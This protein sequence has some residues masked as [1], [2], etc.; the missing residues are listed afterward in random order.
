MTPLATALGGIKRSWL[1]AVLVLGSLPNPTAAT[2]AYEP[3]QYGP[4]P[5]DGSPGV[6]YRTYEPHQRRATSLL[7]PPAPS[8]AATLPAAWSNGGSANVVISQDNRDARLIAYDS[9]ASNLVVGDSNGLRDVFVIRRANGAANFAGRTTLASV[10]GRATRANG[11]SSKPSL[12]GDTWHAPHCVAFESGATNLSSGDRSRD[13]DVY[14]R[15]LGARR[16]LL[17]SPG[18]RDAHEPVIDGSCRTVIFTARGAVWIARVKAPRPRFIARGGDAD[19]QTNGRGVAYARGGQVWY[20]ALEFRGK[21]LVRGRERLVSVTA[22]SRPG[23]GPSASPALDDRGYYVAFESTASNLCVGQC[24]LHDTNGAT[25]DVFRRT[26]SHSAPSHDLMQI[27][28]MSQGGVLQPGPSNNPVISANGENVVFDSAAFMT[29]SGGS[30]DSYNSN[31]TARSVYTWTYPHARGYGN[32]ANVAPR[33]HCYR[34]CRS[35]E[36]R[37]AMSSRGNYVAYV[38]QMSEFCVTDRIFHF[39]G[40]R[41]DCPQ[42][43][44]VFITY[45]G[46]SH[47]GRKLG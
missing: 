36:E 40:E 22:R 41:P 26:M 10:A 19:L 39:D 28:S 38:S 24:Q 11:P 42:F 43:Q 13:A 25:S 12:D 45:M 6:G 31:G 14:V 3:P 8:P 35:A 20:R 21:R 23:N 2:A 7:T 5:W 30:N 29:Q 47:E 17:V 15:D 37:P 33:P 32:V 44:D 18:L 1:L 34:G 27:V 46:R 4:E 9:D 16:T